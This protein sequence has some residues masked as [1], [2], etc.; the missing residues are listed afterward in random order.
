MALDRLPALTR[1]ARRLARPCLLGCAALLASGCHY[2][3]DPEGTL[4]RVRGGVVRVGVVSSPPWVRSPDQGEASGPEAELARAVAASVEARV[5]WRHDSVDALMEQLG[6][7]ELDLV[8][9]GLTE[10]TAWKSHVA[11]SIPHATVRREG[12]LERHVL[13][14]P[15]GEN[16]WLMQ[17]ESVLRRH[18]GRPAQEEAGP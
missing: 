6:R 15:P 12:K 2:P 7:R 13:A 4:Q 3:R 17:V 10:Q 16:A 14:L 5:D 11:L 18:A 9:A 1:F 8:I